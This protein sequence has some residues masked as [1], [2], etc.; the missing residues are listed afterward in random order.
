MEDY[1]NAYDYGW[2]IAKGNRQWPT[3]ELLGYN[4][5]QLIGFNDGYRSYQA[6]QG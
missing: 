6:K 2:Q 4:S 5:Y 3:V 1:D